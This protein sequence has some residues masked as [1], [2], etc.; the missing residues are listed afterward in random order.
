MK[1]VELIFEPDRE[2]HIA[3]HHVSIEE[4][5]QIVFGNPFIR[6]ARE[7]RYLIIGQTE[8]GRYVAVF[9]APRGRDIYALVTAR[10][11]DDAERRAYQQHRR[12]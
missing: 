2:E 6:K 1:I 4:V 9:V 3:R 11:A 7:G 8:A 12:R 5:N 10:E